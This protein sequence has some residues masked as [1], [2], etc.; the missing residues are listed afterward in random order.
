V[1]RPG[2]ILEAG[3]LS[4]EPV[5]VTH[6]IPENCAMAVRTSHGI[7]FFTGDFKFDFTPVDGK[8]ANITR[9]G[10]L[11]REG[12]LVLLSDSTNVERPGL[13]PKRESR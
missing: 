9:I 10:E 13:G 3:K 7:V 4:V 8:L 5:R 11:G 2:D 12:V 6:S 1:F